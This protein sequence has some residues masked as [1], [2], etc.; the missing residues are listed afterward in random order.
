[1]AAAVGSLSRSVSVSGSGVT[2]GSAGSSSAIWVHNARTYGAS[3][4]GVFDDRGVLDSLA[5]LTIGPSGVLYLPPGLYLIESN[6]STPVGV[7]LWFAPGARL[8]TNGAVTITIN[9]ELIAPP[10]RFFNGSG[11][12]A[13][14]VSVVFGSKISIVRAEWF[15]AL[16]GSPEGV[17]S[18][19][20]GTLFIQSG[21]ANG[22]TLWRK[23][24]GSGNTGWELMQGDLGLFNASDYADGG[25]VADASAAFGALVNGTLH[26]AGGI[27]RIGTSVH[28]LETVAWDWQGGIV[29]IDAGVTLTVS[30]PQRGTDAQR[31][32]GAGTVRFITAAA[33]SSSIKPKHFGAVGDGVTVDDV[34][35]QRWTRCWNACTVKPVVEWGAGSFVATEQVTFGT[36]N[37]R[38]NGG[39]FRGNGKL[40]STLRW[41]GGSGK[42]GALRLLNVLASEISSFAITSSGSAAAGTRADV[43][44]HIDADNTT[45]AGESG[46]E[47]LYLDNGFVGIKVGRTLADVNGIPST[48]F[49]DIDILGAY[50]AIHL[51]GS[52]TDGQRFFGLNTNSC[53][54]IIRGE[55]ARN[56]HVDGFTHSNPEFGVGGF[57]DFVYAKFSGN[58]G[59]GGYS[60]RNGRI[61]QGATLVWAGDGRGVNAGHNAI[62]DIENVTDTGS[63]TAATATSAIALS[64]AV[65]TIAV[66]RAIGLYVGQVIRFRLDGGAGTSADT[67]TLTAV[68]VTNATTGAGTIAGIFSA[69]QPAGAAF[70]PDIEVVHL[71]A[72]G[73]VNIRSCNL[74]A[75]NAHVAFDK[76]TTARRA[77]LVLE[78]CGLNAVSGA[79][80]G[81]VTRM[82]TDALA[83]GT[84]GGARVQMR[85]CHIISTPTELPS[86]AIPDRTFRIVPNLAARGTEYP[87]PQC[88]IAEI[89][90]ADVTLFVAFPFN[91]WDANYKVVFSVERVGAA[92]LAAISPT[93]IRSLLVAGF[94]WDLSSAPGAG[95][96]YRLHWK[97]ER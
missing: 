13:G 53:Y 97:L 77:T 46:V 45:S 50:Y 61:E 31:F 59:G 75:V 7:T 73:T 32:S 89:S 70:Y 41:T 96:A 92:A 86:G 29:T 79:G 76:F 49:T 36:L 17:V 88:G 60:L 12:H 84:T 39:V 30:G 51:V 93:W 1:M 83:L 20:V 9:G 85:G 40:V 54:R 6:F 66:S 18:A 11:A 57:D 94:Y 71:G 3:A 55:N 80:S 48:T 72:Q 38:T 2:P 19:G 67:I 65:Q 90:G 14:T 82:T 35:L 63:R 68:A 4:N 52:N 37:T 10:D 91:E 56:V 62:I 8:V 23:R 27:Y 58:L 24:R 26:L 87:D 47:H 28:V 42:G 43:L 78:S 34:A 95:T 69:N 81:N 5:N 33:S 25:G 15:N 44:L 16:A 22:K 64:G 74:Q 21:G